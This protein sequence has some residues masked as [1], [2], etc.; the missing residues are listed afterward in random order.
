MGP[1]PSA[2][3]RADAQALPRV[4]L[5]TGTFDLEWMPDPWGSVDLASDWLLGLDEEFEPDVVHLNGYAH[6][7][8]PWRAPVVIVAHSCVASWWQA[9]HGCDAPS[10]WA[11]YRG[12][13]A[14]GL[15]AAR[16]LVAPSRAMAE[17]I[18]RHYG[19]SRPI[20]VIPNARDA[21]RWT[22]RPKQPFVLAAGRLWDPAK[23]LM[24]PETIAG[25]IAWPMCVA[26]DSMAPSGDGVAMP[27]VCLLGRL[28][29]RSVADVMAMAA[30]YAFP[31][32]YEPFGLSVLEAALAECALVLGDIESLRENWDGVARF[33]RPDRPD[34]LQRVLQ[35]LIEQPAER[36]ALGKAARTRGQ[37][38][39]V[40]AQVR[41][42]EQL[43]EEVVG[44][45]SDC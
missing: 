1:A 15:E 24:A 22:A 20:R 6:G 4:T 8:L 23:N 31:A 25:D 18:A 33:V 26:G 3:Q 30:I 19:V 11:E 5:R 27:R 35:Q 43:Y 29:A 28:P 2:E 45:W 38:F 42:Y 39:S 41:A 21:S 14:A 44:T 40:D 13:V 7:S 37:R 10:D 12:R 9:V 16:M 36:I 32:R 34:E 17:A